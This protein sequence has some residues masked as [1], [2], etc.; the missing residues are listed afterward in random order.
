[1]PFKL[2]LDT[3]YSDQVI[4]EVLCEVKTSMSSTKCNELSVMFG[5]NSMGKID[6]VEGRSQMELDSMVL[7]SKKFNRYSLKSQSIL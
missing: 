2:L 3:I 4:E 1:V 6:L 7:I 5:Q